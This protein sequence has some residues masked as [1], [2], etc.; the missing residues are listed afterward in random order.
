MNVSNNA[1]RKTL[2]NKCTKTTSNDCIKTC[3]ECLYEIASQMTVKNLVVTVSKNVSRMTVPNR[4]SN[5]CIKK[6]LLNAC[7]RSRAE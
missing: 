4:E 7:A 6:P 5:D 3:V 2:S 1:A